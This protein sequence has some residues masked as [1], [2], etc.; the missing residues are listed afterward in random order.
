MKKAD[1]ILPPATASRLAD[2]ERVVMHALPGV[3]RLILFGS[4]ARGEAAPDS[5][6]DVA[7]VAR[8]LS[9]RRP[10][11]RVLSDLI[12]LRPDFEWLCHSADPAA[13]RLSGTARAAHGIG[14]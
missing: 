7:V 1:G 5:D 11:R 3:E 14:G 6:Y 8:D 4:W 12:S 13:G 9:D 2:Y 10:I